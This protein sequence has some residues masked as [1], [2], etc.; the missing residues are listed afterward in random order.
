MYNI[1]ILTNLITILE[2]KVA[3]ITH[4][5]AESGVLEKTKEIEKIQRE[6]KEMREKIE[7]QHALLKEI[8]K[9]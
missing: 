8:W 9:K 3:I 5:L 1:L 4:R 2:N 7:K 6:N